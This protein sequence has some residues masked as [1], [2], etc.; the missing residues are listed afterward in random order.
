MKET[1]RSDEYQVS[2]RVRI[3]RGDKFKAKDGPY[4]RS[5]DGTKVSMTSKGPYVF[6][7]HV[8]RGSL[9]WIEAIDKSGNYC[10]LHVAGKRKSVDRRLVTRPYRVTGKKRPLDV[11]RRGR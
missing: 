6:R 8:K 3:S 1:V 2:A 9:E 5:S 4:W 10:V 7:C 11:K